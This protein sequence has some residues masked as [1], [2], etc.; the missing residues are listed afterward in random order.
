ME[1]EEAPTLGDD[2]SVRD[3]A[4]IAGEPTTGSCRT[5]ACFARE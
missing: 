4:S 1:E 5:P 2:V 3:P